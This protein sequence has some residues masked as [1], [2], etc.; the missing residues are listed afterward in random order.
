MPPINGKIRAI[1]R[2]DF[3]LRGKFGHPHEAGVGQFHFP[4]AVFVQQIEDG[5]GFGGE[6]EIQNQVAALN[7][8][9]SKNCVVQVI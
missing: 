9:H 2:P 1:H 6:I 5:L 7:E 3:A 4:V 8:F